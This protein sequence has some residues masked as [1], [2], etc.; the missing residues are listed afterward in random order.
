VVKQIDF[1]ALRVAAD[2][3]CLEASS[4]L[5]RQVDSRPPTSR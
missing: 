2:I 1:V 5:V 3:F 4:S